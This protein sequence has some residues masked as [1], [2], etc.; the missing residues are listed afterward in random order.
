MRCYLF[1][2]HTEERGIYLESDGQKTTRVPD[3]DE[4]SIHKLKG[5]IDFR[6]DVHQATQ[7]ANIVVTDPPFSLFREYVEQLVNDKK[8]F[9]IIGHNAITYKEIFTLIKENKL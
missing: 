7:Q 2:Q 6:S 3:P 5:D 4:I 8:Q 9:V 1:S